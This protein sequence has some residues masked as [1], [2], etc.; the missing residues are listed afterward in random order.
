MA[1]GA[2]VLD[3]AA[4]F[5]RVVAQ[6]SYALSFRLEDDSTVPH[7]MYLSAD[8][9]SR[10]I[11]YTPTDEGRLLLIGGNGHEVG[12][13]PHTEKRVQELVDALSPGSVERDNALN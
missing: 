3:R 8:S 12:R 2:P 13:E 5:S 1:T 6:R 11:C 7:G 10:S 9:P 4:H